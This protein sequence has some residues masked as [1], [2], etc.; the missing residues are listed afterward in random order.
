MSQ[1]ALN[2]QRSTLLTEMRDTTSGTHSLESLQ[3]TVVE[4]L[5]RTKSEIVV[6]IYAHGK[7]IG[8]IDI[9]SHDPEAFTKDDKMLLEEIAKI[10]GTY[11][12]ERIN[13]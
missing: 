5:S 3:Q 6:P 11:V 10:V 13:L 4:V 1:L 8:E 9:N 7:I 2:P 12:E